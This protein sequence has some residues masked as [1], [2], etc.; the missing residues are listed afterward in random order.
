MDGYAVRFNKENEWKII[1]AISAGNY[2]QFT[3]TKNDAV[4]I[5]TGSKIPKN[6]DTVIP[7]E[8][9]VVS[10]NAL[11]LKADALYKR[12]MD[13]RTMGNDLR[14]G[15]IAVGRF[16]KIDAKTTAVLASCGKEKV[17]VF[18]KLKAA[19]LATGDELI[20]IHERP[21][22]DKLRVSNTY[23]IYAALKEMKQKP[24]MLDF[25]K[26]DKEII[27]NKI[28]TALEL[29]IDILITTGGVSVGK[30]DF[31]KEIFE[32]AGVKEKFWKLNIKPG[33]PVY[34]GVYE[35]NK[36]RIL[37]FGLPG[38]PVSSLVNFYIFIKPAIDHLFHQNYI[39]QIT[40]VLLDDLKKKDSERHF[41]R[42]VLYQENGE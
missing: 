33:K 28:R 24:I 38:N 29:D 1:G 22:S 11:K 16:T 20:P 27:L 34:F 36:K 2:S 23:S 26:D 37:V 32:E 3:I 18:S 35:K 40:A 7:I 4:L 5:T 31:L 21:L 6:T 10:G 42:G 39:N 14:K 12:G 17:K 30:Y 19:I 8:D 41:S 13:I 15:H 25:I 9:T